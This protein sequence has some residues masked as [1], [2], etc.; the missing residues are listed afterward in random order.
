MWPTNTTTAMD[1][2]LLTKNTWW[3]E[4]REIPNYNVLSAY[5]V[6]PG[7][8]R[9]LFSCLSLRFPLRQEERIKCFSCKYFQNTAALRKINILTSSSSETEQ[10]SI[11]YFLTVARLRT[12]TQQSF[13]PVFSFSLL[14]I[15]VKILRRVYIKRDDRVE[16][17]NRKERDSVRRY[18][19]TASKVRAS[20]LGIKY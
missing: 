15:I 18:Q 3:Y 17:N 19:W 6:R 20:V 16:S 2:T 10:P 1:G 12:N 9:G 11:C 14:R 7:S 13:P 5:V 4:S 8:I